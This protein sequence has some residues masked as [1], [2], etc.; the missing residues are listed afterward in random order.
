MGAGEKQARHRTNYSYL[1]AHD[2]AAWVRSFDEALQVACRDH[3]AMRFVGLG[4][5]MSYRAVAVRPSLQMLT[6]EHVRP[7]YRRAARR[8]IL[9]GYDGTM[10]PELLDEGKRAPSG[11][12]LR[13][14]DEL[15]SRDNPWEV[16]DKNQEVASGTGWEAVAERA[17]RQYSEAT[18][19]SYMEMKETAMAWHYQNAD[20]VLG[21]CQA[22]ELHDHLVGVLANEPASVAI[23]SQTVEVNPQVGASKGVAVEGLLGAMAR[24]GKAPDL[25]LCAGD[26]EVMFAALARA[27][28]AAAG[29][30]AGALLPAGA[31]VFACTVGRKA[32]EA[33]FYVDEPADVVGLLAALVAR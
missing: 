22:K 26:G 18:H 14:L 29:G 27:A 8:L 30:G 23:G 32:S 2:A 3:P 6:A 7:A 4:L 12:V 28:R 5:G 13:L 25:V 11:G 10:V 21:P 20:P 24:R 19:G 15:W 17:M 9:L 16:S 31:S 33:A 1:S